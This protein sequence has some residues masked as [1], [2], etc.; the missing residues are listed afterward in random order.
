MRAHSIGFLALT[1]CMVVA[2]AAT[3]LN[4]DNLPASTGGLV[5]PGGVTPFVGAIV[6]ANYSSLVTFTVPT[7]SL[8]VYG[9]AA[10]WS[11]NP[12]ASLPNVVCPAQAALASSAMCTEDLLVRFN[13]A[14]NALSFWAAA[15]DDV[16]SILVIQ[17]FTG[18]NV[19]TNQIQVTSP[20]RLNTQ[21]IINVSTLSGVANITGLR[22]ISPSSAFTSGAGDRNGLVYDNFTFD[23]PS[24]PPPPPPPP[25]VPEPATAVLALAGCAALAAR[26]FRG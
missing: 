3:I 9:E 18:Q 17:V 19:F 10:V 24:V 16:G 4:F 23:L 21:G 7:G 13:Q 22:I 26:R 11:N 15:W 14:V 1:L 12:P 25:P 5:T 8:Y 20:Q 6:P 2:P